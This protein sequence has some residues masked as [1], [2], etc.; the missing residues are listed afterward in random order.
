MSEYSTT[1]FKEF[2]ESWQKSMNDSGL[3]AMKNYGEMMN[4]F[5]DTWKKTWRS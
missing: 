5:T 4:K 1:S 3:E 2:G